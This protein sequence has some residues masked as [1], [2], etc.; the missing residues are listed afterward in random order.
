MGASVKTGTAK[1]VGLWI[2]H[3]KAFIVVLR[4]DAVSTRS[5]LSNVG[6]KVRVKGGSRSVTP[7]G[8][9]EAT[10]ELRRDRRWEKH[11][12]EYYDQVLS[13]ISDAA[14]ILILGPGEAKADLAKRLAEAG[15]GE[16]RV[17][18]EA[19][20]KLTE[21]QIVERIKT[22]YGIPTRKTF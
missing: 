5:V 4:G 20:D 6:K 7:Y 3:E 1:N 13:E 10:Y 17:R 16:G 19:A 2:D 8:P 12:G 21:P 18:A 15:V 14:A 11:L 9:Q 22:H